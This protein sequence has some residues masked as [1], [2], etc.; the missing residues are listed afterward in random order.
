MEKD[1]K[2]SLLEFVETFFPLFQTEKYPFHKEFIEKLEELINGY[3][4]KPKYIKPKYIHVFGDTLPRREFPKI[5]FDDPIELPTEHPL[6]ENDE[7]HHLI[8]HP[9]KPDFRQ[10]QKRLQEKLARKFKGKG[11]FR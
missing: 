6:K 7:L 1:F 9:H 5:I 11:K 4:I 2:M 8:T 10:E 3:E